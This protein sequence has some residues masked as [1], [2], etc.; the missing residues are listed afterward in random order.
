MNAPRILCIGDRLTDGHQAAE[1]EI[2]QVQTATEAMY[3]LSN[4]AFD[5]IWIDRDR[6]RKCIDEMRRV[7]FG[8]PSELFVDRSCALRSMDELRKKFEHL[9]ARRFE[10][11]G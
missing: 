10:P 11:D 3:R 6:L 2:V 5:A 7:E 1:A 4:Q 8:E 9:H